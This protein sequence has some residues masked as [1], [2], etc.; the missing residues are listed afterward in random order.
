MTPISSPQYKFHI[1]FL[2]SW[3]ADH[4]MSPHSLLS[5]SRVL[6]LDWF[7]ISQFLLIGPF[8]LKI[9][10]P[11]SSQRTD[12][13][14]NECKKSLKVL[15]SA[16]TSFYTLKLHPTAN[17]RNIILTGEGTYLLYWHSFQWNIYNSIVEQSCLATLWNVLQAPLTE[18]L[19]C[20]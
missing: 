12:T 11:V 17:W 6:D 16:H 18:L 19:S 1:L 14:I 20:G 5:F 2:T 7:V 9:W 3:T 13:L 15:E 8:P 4:K 10:F